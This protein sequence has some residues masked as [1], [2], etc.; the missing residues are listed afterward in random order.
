VY[1]VGIAQQLNAVQIFAMGVVWRRQIQESKRALFE[2]AYE[3]TKAHANTLDYVWLVQVVL[4][5]LQNGTRHIDVFLF[6]R[7]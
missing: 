6:G 2:H 3:R 5:R 4:S 7:Y 1:V